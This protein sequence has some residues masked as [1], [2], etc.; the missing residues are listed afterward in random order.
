MFDDKKKQS[1]NVKKDDLW[2]FFDIQK[3]SSKRHFL[4]F[5]DEFCSLKINLQIC[6]TPFCR[7]F[8]QQLSV[9]KIGV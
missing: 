5:A 3:H 6:K 8:L 9:R 4:L 2:M 1:A 7:C